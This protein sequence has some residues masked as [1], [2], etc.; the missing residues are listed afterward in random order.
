MDNSTFWRVAQVFFDK[1]N[2][3]RAQPDGYALV[4]AATKPIMRRISPF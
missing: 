2:K 4:I 1:K 3:K